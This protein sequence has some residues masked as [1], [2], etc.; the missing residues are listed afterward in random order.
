MDT[1]KNQALA[2]IDEMQ[3]FVERFGA[4]NKEALRI[5]ERHVFA[6]SCG[7]SNFTE[8]LRSFQMWAKTGLSQRKYKPWGLP[9]VKQFALG[10]LL[11]ARRFASRWPDSP[12]YRP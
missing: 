7:D 9:E 12:G 3:R 5:I 6:L 10:D 1:F 2:A 11:L 4:P 8:K